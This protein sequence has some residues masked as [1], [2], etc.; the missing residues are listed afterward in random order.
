MRLPH[1]EALYKDCRLPFYDYH[2]HSHC[3]QKHWSYTKVRNVY[4]LLVLYQSCTRVGTENLRILVGRVPKF[5]PACNSCVICR[6][7]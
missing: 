1:K 4:G 7:F 2:Y 5:E 6:D 3:G